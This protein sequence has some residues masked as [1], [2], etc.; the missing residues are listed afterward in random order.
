MA[1]ILPPPTFAAVLAQQFAG[2]IAQAFFFRRYS[3]LAS[4]AMR[5][6]FYLVYD[7]IGAACAEPGQFR[8]PTCPNEAAN[9][10]YPSL[11]SGSGAESRMK[12]SLRHLI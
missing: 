10:A 3:L 7:G 1:L 4:V 8:Q 11:A 2:N 12:R 9:H 5:R 6:A